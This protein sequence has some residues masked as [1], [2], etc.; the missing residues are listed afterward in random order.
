[1][2]VQ[3][4]IIVGGGL[5]GK[6]LAFYLLKQGKQVVVV[7]QNVPSTSSKIGAGIIHPVTGRRIV[8]TWMAD[9]LIPFAKSFY[10]EIEKKYQRKIFH[11]FP[12]LEIFGS[13]KSKNDW[14]TRSSEQGFENY[15]SEEI[16]PGKFSEFFNCDFGGILLKGT[17]YVD[18]PSYLECIHGKL[19]SHDTLIEETFLFDDLKVCES[20]VLW[21]NI[22]ASKI[23]FCDG[24]NCVSNPFFKHIPF[25]PA[26]GEILKIFCRDLPESFILN[27]SMFVLPVG[28]HLFKAGSTYKWNFEN[29]DP[30]QEGKN[31]IIKF[32]DGFLKVEYEIVSHHAAVRPTIQD[33]RPVIGLHPKYKSIGVFNG[34]G[35]KGALL[36]PYF[37]KQFADFLLSSENIDAEVNV[38]RFNL[39]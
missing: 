10:E 17:G 39:S 20:F 1:M 8:K 38:S 12:I 25:L 31:K 28:N 14:V 27:H 33:R 21:K 6:T 13:A 15:F 30:S 19:N 36:A 32:L 4:F 11:S 23:I 2:N 24:H 26:K 34:L 9:T 22:Q 3:D 5:A 18:L 35:T 37:A 16:K 29:T 7:D